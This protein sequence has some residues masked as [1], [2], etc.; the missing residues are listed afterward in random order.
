M[1]SLPLHPKHGLNPTIAKCFFCGNDRGDLLLLGAAYKG[2]APKQMCVDHEPCD[3]CKGYM[4]MGIMLIS[5]RDGETGSENPYRTG[6]IS[7]IKEEAAKKIFNGLGDS[8]F[9]YV[10]DKAWDMVGLPRENINNLEGTA[11]ENNKA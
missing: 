3:T 9:A 1:R 7:V 6:C 2:E 5:V 8:R 4:E 11:N 10:E